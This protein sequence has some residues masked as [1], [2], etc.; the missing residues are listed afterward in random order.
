MS[1]PILLTTAS[2]SHVGVVR[3]ENQDFMA[4][5]ERPSG[6][7]LLVVADGMGGHLG[8]ATASRLCVESIGDAFQRS[9]DDPESTASQ[10]E[11]N[12]VSYSPPM[13]ESAPLSSK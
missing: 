3:S 10:S 8:G 11:T 7:R 4:E 13:Q 5:F 1:A 6:H 9:T 12:G 2:K